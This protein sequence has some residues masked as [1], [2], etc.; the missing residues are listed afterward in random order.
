VGIVLTGALDDGT[1][2]LL[3]VKRRGGV[4]VVQDPQEALYPGMPTS[5]MEN[6][7]VDYCLPLSGIGSLIK[8]LSEEPVEE[9]EAYPVS[10]DME[11]ETKL[12]QMNMDAFNSEEHPRNVSAFSCPECGGVL[13]ELQDGELLRFRCRVGHAFSVDSIQAE[14]SDALEEALWSSLKT[15]EESASLSHRMMKL[16]QQRGQDWLVRTYEKKLQDA[17]HR[18]IVIKQV[19]MKSEITPAIEGQASQDA[20]ENKENAQ[21]KRDMPN[22]SV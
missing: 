19:L 12:A 14:Q 2:G 11:M 6:M 10:E 3:A 17:K 9:E 16:A 15:L 5:V 22:R 20:L 1:A 13:W 4:A 8:C 21:K 18:A 7:E